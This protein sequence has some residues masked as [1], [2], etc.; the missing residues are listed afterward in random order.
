MHLEYGALLLVVPVQQTLLDKQTEYVWIKMEGMFGDG[1]LRSNTLLL[2]SSSSKVFHLGALGVLWDFGS[3][4]GK[5][6]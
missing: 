1:N 5:Q 2:T 3:I 4:I 6:I